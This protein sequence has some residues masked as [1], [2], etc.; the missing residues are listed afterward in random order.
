MYGSQILLSPG[1]G[2]VVEAAD[3]KW[4][5]SSSVIDLNDNAMIVGQVSTGIYGVVPQIIAAYDGGRWDKPGI[6]S[7]VAAANGSTHR[8]AL[9]YAFAGDIGVTTFFDRTVTSRNQL[10]RYTYC[11]DSNLDGTVDLTDFTYLAANFNGSGK[12]WLQGDYNYDGNIDLTDFTLLA[13]NFN[14][15]LPSALLG[16]AIPEPA[17][18]ALMLV[19]AT[20][21]RARRSRRAVSAA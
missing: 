8:T 19:L 6:T 12:N 5:V 21:T 3:S 17:T 18:M 9:G 7:S 13:S 1:G 16:A 10:V 11:G 15:A 20:V 2:K 14:Q 4:Q